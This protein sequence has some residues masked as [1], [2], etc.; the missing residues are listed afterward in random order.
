MNP[1]P[2]D[3]VPATPDPWE[4]CR[5]QFRDACRSE[6]PPGIADIPDWVAEFPIDQQEDLLADLV[7]VHLNESQKRKC[8]LCQ[9]AGI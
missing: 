5:S 4:D 8:C 6:K 3:D 2:A 9:R 1:R 7:S